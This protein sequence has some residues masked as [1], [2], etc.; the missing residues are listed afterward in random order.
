MLTEQGKRPCQQGSGGVVPGDQ[1]RQHLVADEAIRETSV[2]EV[3]EQIVGTMDHRR[4]TMVRRP[5]SAVGN[6]LIKIIIQN[7]QM[8][9]ESGVAVSFAKRSMP[10]ARCIGWL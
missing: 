4:W 6:D 3:L 7:L 5:S 8:F 2:D 1:H 10:L 9:P